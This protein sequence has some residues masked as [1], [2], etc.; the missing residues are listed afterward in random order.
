[1][2][3]IYDTFGLVA[4]GKVKNL[5]IDRVTLSIDNSGS[6]TNLPISIIKQIKWI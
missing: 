1:M 2:V 3:K 5:S 4:K 6:T